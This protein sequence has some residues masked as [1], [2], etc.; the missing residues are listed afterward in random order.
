M[1]NVIDY[2]EPI[3]SDSVSG[4]QDARQNLEQIQILIS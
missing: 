2:E 3:T 1:P 4:N